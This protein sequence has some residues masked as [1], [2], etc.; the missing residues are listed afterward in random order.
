MDL[1]RE[2]DESILIVEDSYTPV[3]EVDGF[4]RQKISKDLAGF[5][6]TI[7]QLDLMDIYR[8]LH[9]TT[10]EYTYFSSSH[11]TFTKIDDIMGHWTY[12]N[13]FKRI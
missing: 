12:L 2:I 11:R 5:N 6:S 10:A 1:Q 3:P 9:G 8:L 7:N 13:K 4:S